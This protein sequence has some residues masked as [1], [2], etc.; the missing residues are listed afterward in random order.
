MDNLYENIVLLCEK[1][2][3]SD[4]TEAKKS[5]I[6]ILSNQFYKLRF[7]NDEEIKSVLSNINF[8]EDVK[9]YGKFILGKIEENNSKVSVF[10]STDSI[11]AVTLDLRIGLVP[12]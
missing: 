9:Q 6:E 12:W 7:P 3:L 2:M 4:I 11:S 8:Y 1:S 5:L 10:P